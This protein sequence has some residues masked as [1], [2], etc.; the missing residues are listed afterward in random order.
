MYPRLRGDDEERRE[1]KIVW[2]VRG[3]DF[4]NLYINLF[5]ISSKMIF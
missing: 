2:Q 5:I 4:A 3:L 1:K